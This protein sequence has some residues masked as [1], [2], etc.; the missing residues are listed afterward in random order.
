MNDRVQASLFRKPSPLEAFFNR[1]LGL[2]VGLG[3]GPVY[4]ELLQV[5]GRQ[6]RTCLLDPG[7]S[8][9]GR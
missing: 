8:S 5:R 9:P 7:K 3:I 2:L 1:A 4:M 6:E